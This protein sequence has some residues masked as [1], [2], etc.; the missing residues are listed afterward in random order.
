MATDSPDSPWLAP[1]PPLSSSPD[2]QSVARGSTSQDWQHTQGHIFSGLNTPKELPVTISPQQQAHCHWQVHRYG[3][4]D[5]VNVCNIHSFIPS[6]AR[7][8]MK[9]SS[10][11]CQRYR[12]AALMVPFPQRCTLEINTEELTSSPLSSSSPNHAAIPEPCF[13]RPCDLARFLFLP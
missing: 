9:V 6:F 7:S 10:T 3:Q 2:A 1:S 12:H 11:G 13:L 8:S 5:P 4:G